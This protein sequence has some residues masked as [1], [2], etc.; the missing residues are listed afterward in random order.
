MKLNF[1]Q[2][3]KWI[4]IRDT[5]K[6]LHTFFHYV[7]VFSFYFTFFH[8]VALSKT[9][10]KSLISV[11][12][13]RINVLSMLLSY[14]ENNISER[15][16]IDISNLIFPR[17]IPINLWFIISFAFFS[18]VVSIFQIISELTTFRHLL[19]KFLSKN[20]TVEPFPIF[21]LIC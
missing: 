18:F 21:Q 16:S 17:F 2:A 12:E 6:K 14:N 7:S 11:S 1:Q 13:H 5:Y 4:S 8:Y 19:C 3:R 20:T 9:K 15:I 10:Q